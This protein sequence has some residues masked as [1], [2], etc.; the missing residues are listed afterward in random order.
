M[1]ENSIQSIERA[2]EIIE[3]LA[4]EPKGLSITE[5]SK[6]LALHKSTVHRILRTLLSRGYVE[7]DSES[8]RYKLGV[9]FV[10][11]SSLYLNSIE[12]KTEAHPYLRELVNILGTT[13]HLAILD[14]GEVVYIDKVE[15][16]NSIRLYSSIGKRVPAYC[17]A[18]G[19]ILLTKFSDDDILKIL[20]EIGLKRFTQNTITDPKK[21]LEEIQQA[22]KFG[23]AVDNE[24]FQ[25]GIRCISAPIYDYRGE[26]I[27]AISASAPKHIFTPDRDQ[28]VAKKVVETA[29]KVSYRLGY[30]E[31]K[32]KFMK[33]ETQQNG[34]GT[35]FAEN[36]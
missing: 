28:E 23:W 29:K 26:L 33:G 7:K 14:K 18:L 25:D 16:V 13:V 2:F 8:M 32:G 5:L 4:V 31:G 20:N 21:V 19:K 12:L 9:K 1:A 27:A 36:S 15:Q 35:S 3:T 22:R 6:R 30:V 34:K 10:E 24:E 17:T 11:I